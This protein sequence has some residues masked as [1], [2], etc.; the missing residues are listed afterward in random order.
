[1]CGIAGFLDIAG[2]VSDPQATLSAMARR[3]IHR[4]PD[5]E[6]ISFDHATRCGLAFRRLSILE[7]SP[8]GHQ[9][10]LSRSGRFEIVFNGEIYNHGSLRDE[11]I[12]RGH[13]FAGRSDTEVM[14]AMFEEYGFEQSLHR[15][16]GMFAC[17][18]LDRPQRVLWLARDRFGVKPLLYGLS[19]ARAVP[20]SD[21]MLSAG[22][23]LVFS[24]ELKAMHAMPRMSLSVDRGALALFMQ[25]GHVPA[26]LSIHPEVRK[27]GAGCWLRVDIG[28]RSVQQH[29]WWSSR[30]LVQSGVHSPF[31]GSDE[32]AIEAVDRAIL[33]SVR[34]RMDADVSLG[35]FLSGGV[36]STAVVA[37]MQ[38]QSSARV[39]TYTIGF[40][41]HA[42]NEAPYARAIAAH[43][44]TDHT[45]RIVTGREA[46][47]V[48]PRLIEINDEP[49]ADSSQI[50]T[51]LL[52]DCAR[53][54]VT[55]ALSGDGGDELFGG[56]YR[57]SWIPRLAARQQ[58]IPHRV[59]RA[60]ARVLAAT[61]RVL[62]NRIG[63]ALAALAPHMM[64]FD[65]AGDR[66][67]RLAGLLTHTDPW[68]I[69][70][71]LLC[72]SNQP[73]MLTEALAP[74][75]TTLD[76]LEESAAEVDL[77][78]QLMH[79]DIVGYLAD[80]ILVKVDRASMAVSLEAREP[81]LDHHLAHLAFSLPGSMRI[82]HGERK[83][84]LR[85]VVDRR[86]P[87]HLMAR[88]KMGFGVPLAAWLRGPLRAW[89]EDLL[90]EDRLRREGFL[91]V[92]SARA[93]WHRLL[94][95]GDPSDAADI[96][97]AL[98]FGAWLARWG[99]G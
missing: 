9:P 14:L 18:V 2:V 65:R 11:L 23:S 16:T 90:A 28:D 92:K 26:P 60:L 49:F 46:L 51:L 82:R 95:T 94:E 5:D 86:V 69:Y 99:R 81:L 31:L 96:W 27:L 58:K 75:R 79:A 34:M 55:V 22:D 45:E 7:L 52:C 19:N 91:H 93:R 29:A 77:S 32:D 84:I 56:Y 80:D 33:H 8:A 15:F 41:D 73:L 50:P 25:R 1:M 43:L 20:S 44:G 85:Q 35:A 74:P 59:R 97:N 4:G 70:R 21:F 54:G 10:M 88:P 72:V 57:H 48:L 47:D 6:G 36:D 13:V 40:D 61:P 39:R 17:A 66:A 89:A 63:D 71:S 24:S 62:T 76:S 3:L 67:H 30:T 42:R 37:A 98:S 38:A 53:A 83:W 12:A 87:R 64:P 68:A 78:T